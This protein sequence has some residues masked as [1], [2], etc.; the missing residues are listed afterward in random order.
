M[1][2]YLWR[3]MFY[4]T[5][6]KNKQNK[7]LRNDF[8]LASWKPQPKRAGSWSATQCTDS[9]ILIR[10]KM[11]RIRK[12]GY[13]YSAFVSVDLKGQCHEIF[14]FCFFYES[15]SPKH[16]SIPVR[17]FQIFSKIRGDIR[18]SRFTTGVNDTGGKWKK[19]SSWKIL[20]IL[21]GHLWVVELPY[22]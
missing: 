4:F 13:Y 20:I 10:I 9:R 21:F 6:G 5:Y 7:L 12:T 3:Q 11:T 19:S 17:P 2:C 14:D 8:L 15:V 16:L 22:I 1:A 18:G